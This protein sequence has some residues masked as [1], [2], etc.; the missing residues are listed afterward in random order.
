MLRITTRK[1]IEGSQ[2]DHLYPTLLKRAVPREIDDRERALRKMEQFQAEVA[3][4]ARRSSSTADY[5][6][7][8]EATTLVIASRRKI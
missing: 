1:P 3:M 5:M 8:S 7:E 4:L 2:R 6:S